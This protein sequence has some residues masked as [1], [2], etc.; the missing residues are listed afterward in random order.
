MYKLGPKFDFLIF[1]L[2]NTQI[3]K[4]KKQIFLVFTFR[5]IIPAQKFVMSV[6]CFSL[7]SPICNTPHKKHNLKKSLNKIGKKIE[8][9]L[10]QILFHKV[11]FWNYWN[12]T[13]KKII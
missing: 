3:N 12:H 2:Q 1:I 7:H 6:D 11:K 13:A 9:Y 10:L 8:M 5:S 4:V